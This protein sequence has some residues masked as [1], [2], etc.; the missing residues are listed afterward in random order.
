MKRLTFTDAELDEIRQ[1]APDFDCP[2]KAEEGSITISFCDRVCD[3]FWSNCPFEKTGKKL[4]E[5]EDAEEQGL[6]LKLPCSIGDKLYTVKEW[7]DTGELSVLEYTFNGVERGGYRLM[8][9]DNE[10]D[11]TVFGFGEIG[12]TVF[13]SKEEA[14]QALKQMGE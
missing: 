13:L 2:I 5:Y 10:E 1:Y 7:L 9:A 11:I 14:E 12:K 6:L 3:E 8:Y 4:K